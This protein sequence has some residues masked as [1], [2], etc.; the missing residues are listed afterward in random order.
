MRSTASRSRGPYLNPA[1]LRRCQALLQQSIDLSYCRRRVLN[2]DGIARP[3]G[4]DRQT[5]GK[6]ADRHVAVP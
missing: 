4:I 1:M 6:S 5:A 3:L 2:I